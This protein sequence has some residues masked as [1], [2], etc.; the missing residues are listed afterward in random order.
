MILDTQGPFIS[1]NKKENDKFSEFW[2]DEQ[3]EVGFM[4]IVS[5][6]YGPIHILGKTDDAK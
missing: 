1:L 6:V 3:A 5:Q 4:E 2:Y